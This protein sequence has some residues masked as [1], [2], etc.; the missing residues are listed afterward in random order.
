MHASC[1]ID[2]KKKTKKMQREKKVQ[3]KKKWSHFFPEGSTRVIATRKQRNIVHMHMCCRY[4]LC[5]MFIISVCV[6]VCS[7]SSS[8]S[9]F[10]ILVVVVV[11]FFFFTTPCV[12]LSQFHSLCYN[13]LPCFC[14]CLCSLTPL[15]FL[16]SHGPLVYYT[17]LCFL[18]PCALSECVVV[19]GR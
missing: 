15:S 19:L 4:V 9:F 7:S 14:C 3:M 5:F 8:F 18:C 1:R 17:S 11:F 12:H 13:S 16:V 2:Q 6:Y 10:L